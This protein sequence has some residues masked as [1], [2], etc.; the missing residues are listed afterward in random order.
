ME[1]QNDKVNAQQDRSNV[2]KPVIGQEFADKKNL[3]QDQQAG[4]E[5]ETEEGLDTE[6]DVVEEGKH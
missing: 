5:I 2:T 4:T 6:E 3:K 1:Q